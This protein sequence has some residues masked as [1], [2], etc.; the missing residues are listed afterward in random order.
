MQRRLVREPEA[1]DYLGGISHA[2]MHALRKRGEISPLHIGRSC[3]YD[4]T[5][6]DGYVSRLRAARIEQPHLPFKGV[7][8]VQPE[9]LQL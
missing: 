9:R 5:D 1:R 6:L 7:P 8:T 3:F 2:T 4:V